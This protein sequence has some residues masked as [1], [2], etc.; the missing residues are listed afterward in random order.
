L[1]LVLLLWFSVGAATGQEDALV[2]RG[3]YVFRAAG[4]CSCHTDVKNEGA[5]MA[6]GR[7]IATPFGIIYSTNITPDSETGIG[8]WSDEDFLRAMT[9][10]VGPSGEQYFP[11]FPYTSFTRMTRQD[12][13]DLKAYLFSIPPVEQ[14]NKPPEL[15]APFGW[16]FGV[17]V[18]KWL[19]FQP[20]TLQPD[21]DQ[22][23]QWNRG[24]YLAQAL[25][26]CSE[27]HTPRNLMGG[28]QKGRRHAGTVDGPDGE[29]APN[30]TPD[31]AT[32]IGSWSLADL[33]WFLQMGL[34]PDGDDTQGLMSE[35]IE[36]GY[37]HLSEDDLAAIAV[38]IRSLPPI[39]HKVEPLGD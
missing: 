24:A 26:H 23:P 35:L 4:G 11:V 18:W 5:F 12:V 27:C 13:L 10:G 1:F 38:Y 14:A 8:A 2:E 22:S 20:G 36:T 30:I 19:Y 37:T 29:L 25:G 6:G 32:G 9:L 16:R 31:K 28:L 15:Q 34:K 33:V 17:R 3:A 7:P 21:P 39:H